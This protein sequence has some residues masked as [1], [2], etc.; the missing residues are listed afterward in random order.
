MSLDSLFHVRLIFGLPS[1]LPASTAPL[2][3]GQIG[4]P[5]QKQIN[6]IAK[7]CGVLRGLT[8][9]QLSHAPETKA[10]PHEQ[11]LGEFIRQQLRPL[12]R[13]GLL[14]RDT[15]IKRLFR[16][17]VWITTGAAG[18]WDHR[19][20]AHIRRWRFHSPINVGRADYPMSLAQLYAQRLIAALLLAAGFKSIGCAQADDIVARPI[21][22]IAKTFLILLI[23]NT[24]AG[25]TGG[26][27]SLWRESRPISKNEGARRFGTT[28]LGFHSNRTRGDVAR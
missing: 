22:T 5:L 8:E 24:T 10:M 14:S 20:L 21:D 15:T 6:S 7:R 3:S 23:T 27:R 11:A 18:R 2:S 13:D 1:R 19:R 25:K 16:L 28:P 17:D 26:S 4:L 9:H 12:A